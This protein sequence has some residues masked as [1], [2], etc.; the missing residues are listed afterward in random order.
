MESYKIFSLSI[1]FALVRV[2]ESVS[3]EQEK[4]HFLTCQVNFSNMTKSS[5]M[6]Y[7]EYGNNTKFIIFSIKTINLQLN[8]RLAISKK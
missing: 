8:L 1:A 7:I 6:D 2:F 3:S 5:S 4:A